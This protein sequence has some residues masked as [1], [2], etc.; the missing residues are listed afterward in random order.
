L[1]FWAGASVRLLIMDGSD[2]PLGARGM[3]LAGSLDHVD[4]RH[5][6]TSIPDRLREAADALETEYA[7]MLGDDEFHLPHGLSKAVER[8]DEDPELAG[9]IGQSLYLRLMGSGTTAVFET[10]YPHWRYS[11]RELDPQERFGAAFDPYTPATPYAVLRRNVWQDSWGRLEDWSCP[12]AMEV[13]QAMVVLGHGCVEAVDAVQWLRSVENPR[14]DDTARRLT[15]VPWY[16]SE[17]SSGERGRWMAVVSGLVGRASGLDRAD[18]VRCV[19][20]GSE[21]FGRYVDRRHADAP[22]PR[23]QTADSWWTAGKVRSLRVLQ[24]MVDDQSLLR[25][26]RLRVRLADAFGRTP[27]G[28]LGSPEEVTRRASDGLRSANPSLADDLAGL[29]ELVASFHRRR[30]DRGEEPTPTL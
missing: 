12:A 9:C 25:F 1:A 6:P 2:Q 22:K 8:L 15:F 14:V 13:Q 29:V 24:R 5:R 21:A 10:A 17:A 3:D 23:R 27:D 4:Y 18:A 28:Y 19:V 20:A 26:R 30:A 16:R 7:V 11:R